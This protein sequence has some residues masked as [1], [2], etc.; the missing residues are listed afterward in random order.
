MFRPMML[1]V[2]LVG[3]IPDFNNINPGA[4]IIHMPVR[5]S[6]VSAVMRYA[7]IDSAGPESTADID[8]IAGLGLQ[9][10]QPADD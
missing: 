10:A 4:Q 5:F 6:R 2:S 1:S 7:R 9:A 3:G 8:I